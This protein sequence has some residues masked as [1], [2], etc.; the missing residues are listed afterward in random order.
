[1]LAEFNDET[2]INLL[3]AERA[4][5]Y[6]INIS[7]CFFGRNSN[8]I[9][10][11]FNVLD[12]FLFKTHQLKLHSIIIRNIS[13]SFF[14]SF[15]EKE[16]IIPYVIK[17]FYRCINKTY[18]ILPKNSNEKKETSFMRI[19]FQELKFYKNSLF[20]E[21]PNLILEDFSSNESEFTRMEIHPEYKNNK[22]FVL[23]KE[24]ENLPSL[25]E[26]IKNKINEDNSNIFVTCL[27]KEIEFGKEIQKIFEKSLENKSE[28]AKNLFFIYCP[29]ISN[30]ISNL[31]DILKFLNKKHDE[32]ALADR[33]CE[34][35][36]NLSLIHL[37]KV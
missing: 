19:L 28:N 37:K 35:K 26:K 23:V 7:Y 22:N 34:I 8:N 10:M 12:G 20:S 3:N 36:P 11:L 18:E 4:S 5:F 17:I 6:A 15:Q 30:N 25:I 24:N 29:N 9:K 13:Q 14:N 2:S 16:T 21:L 31:I 27:T 32:Q 1:M 33:F